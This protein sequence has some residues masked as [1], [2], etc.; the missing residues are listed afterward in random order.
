[1]EMRTLGKSAELIGA[2]PMIFHIAKEGY[3][4]IIPAAVV[5]LVFWWMGWVYL[6]GV[7]LGITLFVI[8]FFRN[9]TR[10]P[11]PSESAIV[12]PAD[13][14]I[15]KIERH[16]ENHFL[17]RETL[18][19]S[20]F[21]SLFDVHVNRSPMSGRVMKRVYHPGKFFAANTDKSSLLNER[22]ALLL[23]S[24]DGFE[25]LFIQIAGII[26]RRIVCYLQ[27]GDLVKKGQIFGMIRFGSRVDICLPLD[28]DIGVRVG[29]HVKA[30]ETILGYRNGKKTENRY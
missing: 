29:D 15:V 8:Y 22:N 19:I 1:M 5:T 28:V 11:P 25:I 16:F 21:M 18:K 17:H 4:F 9:P 2:R 10:T 13:G 27:Q 26:A 3:P 14:K 12:S 7:F 23:C 24:R 30:G 6:A 20:I